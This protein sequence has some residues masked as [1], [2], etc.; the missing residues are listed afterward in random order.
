MTLRVLSKEPPHGL[1]RH[2]R[3]Q[4]RASFRLAVQVKEADVP[5]WCVD[6]DVH[7]SLLDYLTLG[8]FEKQTNKKKICIY[9]LLNGKA[10]FIG[11][12]MCRK[13]D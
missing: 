12:F 6:V 7:A 9:M 2:N 10:E 3:V 4:I 5:W 8:S 11:H 1:T 13:N